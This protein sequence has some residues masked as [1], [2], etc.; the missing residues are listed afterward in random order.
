MSFLVI[1]LSNSVLSRASV[2]A[3]VYRDPAISFSVRIPNGLSSPALVMTSLLILCLSIRRIINRIIRLSRYL[4]ECRNTPYC[5]SYLQ[6]R[7]MYHHLIYQKQCR[8][9]SIYKI[10]YCFH[11]LLS[12]FI[13]AFV[14]KYPTVSPL[15][16]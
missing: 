5:R 1:I 16:Y 11:R 10:S 15:L 6:I 2:C 7:K 8:I 3:C 4:L 13:H 9:E 12:M 14:V